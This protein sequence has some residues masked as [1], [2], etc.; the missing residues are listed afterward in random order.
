M[1]CACID[2]WEAT[3]HRSTRRE[4]LPALH[5]TPREVIRLMVNLIFIEDDEALTKPGVV[6]SIYDPTAGTGETNQGT[7]CGLD[8]DR[9]RPDYLGRSAQRW[10]DKLSLVRRWRN[11]RSAEQPSVWEDLERPSFTGNHG[12]P[13]VSE[14]HLL[15]VSIGAKGPPY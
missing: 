1:V 2:G 6:R 13:I 7:F 10:H 4:Y 14:Q 9:P 11:R 12:L 8:P 3:T 15:A 5:F